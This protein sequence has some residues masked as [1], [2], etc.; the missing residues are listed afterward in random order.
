MNIHTK[1]KSIYWQSDLL[2]IADYIEYNPNVKDV[3]LFYKRV[4]ELMAVSATL[5]LTDIHLEN[6]L[7]SDGLPIILDFETLFTFKE[8]YSGIIDNTITD[9]EATLFIEPIQE[10]INQ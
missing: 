1:K 2:N 3:E 5:N 8:T 9:I 7:I 6:L 4:A 10:L